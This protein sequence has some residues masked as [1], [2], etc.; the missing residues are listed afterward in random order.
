MDEVARPVSIVGDSYHLI[1]TVSPTVWL[2]VLV[3]IL[4]TPALLPLSLRRFPA[5]AFVAPFSQYHY[6][7]TYLDR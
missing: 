3:R 4:D 6:L 1:G 2:P 7:V 5:F